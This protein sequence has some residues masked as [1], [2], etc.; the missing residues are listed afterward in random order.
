MDKIYKGKIKGFESS[1]SSGL[2]N[3]VI[4]NDL[5]NIEN[6]PCDNGTTVRSLE[7]AFGDVITDGHTANGKGYMDKEIYYAMESW[8]TMKWFMPVDEAKPEL[9]REYNKQ[10]GIDDYDTKA[11]AFLKKTKVRISIGKGKDKKPLWAK[12]G[13]SWGQHYKV[14]LH[15]GKAGHVTSV[16]FDFWDSIANKE[17]GKRPTAYDFLSCIQKYPVESFEHFCSD[18][19]YDTD[20]I[21]ALKTYKE[22]RKEFAKVSKIFH[23]ESE[24]KELQEIQ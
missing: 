10:N 3:L 1:F 11:R 12:D 19:G 21:L 9:V 4:E 13:Q 24:L 20:S 14:G 5:G 18:F 2:A 6:I 8:G 17:V 15:R 23:R 7:E 22:V 16:Y